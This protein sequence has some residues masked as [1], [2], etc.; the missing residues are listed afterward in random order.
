MKEIAS[1]L[2]ELLP[3]RAFLALDGELGAGKTTFAQYLLASLGVKE[4]V[5]SPT[6]TLLKTYEG[7][8]RAHHLDLYRLDY[9]EEVLDLG[10]WELLEDQALTLVEWQNRFPQL[11]P[12][13]YLQIIFSYLGDIRQL[14]LIA[15]GEEY[16]KI[17]KEMEPCAYLA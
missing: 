3:A 10:W 14:Q 6:F 11:K 7:S 5:I 13:S 9:E 4:Q 12:D 15:Y 17:L 8:K 16:E 2:G 1:V